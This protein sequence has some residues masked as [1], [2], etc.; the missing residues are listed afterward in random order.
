MGRTLVLIATI[1]FKMFV[2]KMFD[3]RTLVVIAMYIRLK[4][5]VFNE[6][7]CVS[8]VSLPCVQ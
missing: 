5:G 6:V 2:F 3:A 7:E 8:C 1:P 4:S